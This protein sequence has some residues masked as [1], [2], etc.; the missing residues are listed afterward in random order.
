MNFVNKGSDYDCLK[1]LNKQG[2][3]KK[4]VQV[5]GKHGTYIR[6][7]WVS[8]G[9][10]TS[11]HNTSSHNHE[12]HPRKPKSLYFPLTD[13]GNSST[14]AFTYADIMMYYSQH[15]IKEP[16]QKFIKE[17]YFV[18]DGSN[19][20][21][22][23]YKSSKGYTKERSKLH[24]NIIQGILDSANSPKNGE[25]PIAVLMGG[26]TASGKGTIRDNVVV[27]KLQSAGINVG[28]TDCDD[29]KEQLPE[30]HHFQQQDPSSAASRVHHE[31]MDIAM[32]AFDELVKNKKNL[33]FDGTMRDVDKYSSMIE[34]LHKAGYH[35]S[36]VGTDVPIE[37]ARQRSEQRSKST[38]RG[39]P[40]GILT[41]T[42]GNF[43]LTYPQLINQVDSYSLY[44]N[45]GSS[46]VLVQD[47]HKTYK[48]DLLRKFKE[49]GETYKIN[50]RIR[51]ISRR[52]NV[53][54]KEIQDI[55]F[56]GATLDEIEEYYSLGLN[57]D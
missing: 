31:S 43:A 32:E 27:P 1:S 2:L 28:I 53:S 19:K 36:I 7:Q 23:F 34:K 54:T 20:T 37:I 21:Q 5:Q 25:K 57:F 24:K 12:S 42:H 47:E 6:K 17:N 11:V 10:Q 13:S 22:D 38:H 50:K 9:G 4:D 26:G 15:K 18:S 46:P 48:P 44:D 16:I 14:R 33:L 3:V 52:Y 29:I 49:K 56:H 55:Y 35:V 41:G 39:V 30:Y 40:E 45:S 51:E 8:A